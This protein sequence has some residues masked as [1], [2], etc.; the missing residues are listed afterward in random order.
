MNVASRKPTITYLTAGAAGMYCGSCMHDNTLARSLTAEGFETV[1][2]PTYTPIRSDEKEVS[3]D[4]VFFGGINVY[5]Q[6]KI[7]L[8]RFVPRFMDRFLD[9]PRLI[10]KVTSR[11]IETDAKMLGGLTVSMLQG[12]G[13]HQR[14]EVKRLVRW[15]EEDMKPE[16]VV[17]SNVLIGGFIP[18]L[19]KKWDVPVIVTLQ[20]DDIFLNS[21][22]E[23]YKRQAIQLIGELDRYVDGYLVHS[24]FYVDLMARDCGLSREK[25]YVTP[26]G[27]DTSDY[28]GLLRAREKS[29]VV[30]IG[31]LA[32]LSEDKG[33]H[34][35][36]TAFLELK[37]R[38]GME[39]VRLQIAGWLGKDHE[40]FADLQFKRLESAGLT[41]SYQY[42]GSV[43]RADKLR[44]FSEMDVLCVPTDYHEPKGLYALEA[45]ACGIPVVQPA[46]GVFPE[47]LDDLGGGL[48]YQPNNPQDL[49]QQLR[50]LILDQELRVALGTTGRNSVLSRRNGKA[51]AES[52]IAVVKQVLSDRQS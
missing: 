38:D 13:G 5:L 49:V 4:Q 2:V 48:L 29:D 15:L 22:S 18:E 23:P 28:I 17:L 50:K 16:I 21:L 9:N 24:N 10:R 3:V 30:N 7:P 52:T 34:N 47:L 31:Y 36:V 25:M 12:K 41:G 40:A 26:L 11:G 39:R 51:M 27:I 1:L 20:G 19:K 44:M 46:H 33:L 37:K 45:M 43:D 32:R 6:E 35:L 8:F 14:K 42:L